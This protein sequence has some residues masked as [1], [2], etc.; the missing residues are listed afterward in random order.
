MAGEV[1]R[2]WRLGYRNVELGDLNTEART[3]GLNTGSK[4]QRPIAV[5]EAALSSFSLEL[6]LQKLFLKD[7]FP[8]Q[9]PKL[10]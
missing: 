3:Q 2:G 7:H 5:S 4:A 6:I 1:G 9:L 10:D 8:P